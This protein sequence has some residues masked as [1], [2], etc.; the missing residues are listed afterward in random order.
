VT[1]ICSGDETNS[2]AFYLYFLHFLTTLTAKIIFLPQ[3]LATGSEMLELQSPISWSKN[4]FRKKIES[5]DLFKQ[6]RG[7]QK[8]NNMGGFSNPTYKIVFEESLGQTGQVYSSIFFA[9]YVFV[10]ELPYSGLCK[11]KIS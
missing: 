5:M 9:I 3:E 11:K 4:I 2:G 7:I 10:D 6:P 8:C 1:K